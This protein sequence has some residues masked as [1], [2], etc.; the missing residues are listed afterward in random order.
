[1]ARIEAGRHDEKWVK[2]KIKAL[3]KERKIWYFMP[4]SGQFGK[5]GVPDFICCANGKFLGIEAKQNSG[6]ATELQISTHTR[7]REA[8]GRVSVVDEDGLE[9]L[10][11]MLNQF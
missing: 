11:I 10:R 7:I 1:M 4:A 6:K 2:E 5:A 3:L 8:G 9:S